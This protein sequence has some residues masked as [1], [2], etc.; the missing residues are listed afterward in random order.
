MTFGTLA[1][2]NLLRNKLRLGLTLL[3]GAV[4]VLAFVFLQTVIHIFYADVAASRA[5]RLVV[6]NKA[7]FTQPLPLSYYPRIANLPAV[8]VAS[9]QTWFG[10][11]LGERRQDF[12]ANFAVDPDT[13]LRVYDDLLLPPEQ[14][15]AFKADPCGA[16]VGADLEKRF[17]WKV[18][19]RVTLKGTL[20]PGQ[21]T[22]T[23]R[24]IF[25]GKRPD[26]ETGLLAFGY[27]CLNEALPE[28]R[29]NLVGIFLVRVDDPLRSSEVANAIDTMFENSPYPTKTESERAFQLGFVSMSS[30]IVAAIRLVSYIILLILLLVIG[31][32]LAMGVR[33]RTSELAT[34]RALGFQRR[35]LIALVM[36]E[37]AVI[38]TGSA[39]LGMAAAP[40]VIDGFSRFVQAQFGPMPQHLFAAS[41]FYLAAAAA[42][43]VAL[44]GGLIPA[45]RAGQV[46]VSRGL[47]QVA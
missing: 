23:V 5:D 44:A 34:L 2:R 7:G 19:E 13:F 35:H 40:S 27:R 38:G 33:E 17:H 39:A 11:Q 22:F 47:R 43:G 1:I 18:G 12:F 6:R 30:A 42:L 29:K 26:V 24:G 3:A 36:L 31:N 14:I 25:R 15:A 10:G 9:Y 4:G 21:W 37:S 20:Y 46:S 32:T 28:A 8:S 16:I 41:T 45:L